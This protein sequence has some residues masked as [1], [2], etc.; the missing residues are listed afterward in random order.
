MT[1]ELGENE[2]HQ[3]GLKWRIGHKNFVKNFKLKQAVLLVENGLY[4][5]QI[6]RHIFELVTVKSKSGVSF[7]NFR[8]ENSGGRDFLPK[9]FEDLVNRN[10]M[11]VC[12]GDQDCL[13]PTDHSNSNLMKKYKKLK[14]KK[15]VGF[16]KFTP[17][18]SIENFFSLTIVELLATRINLSQVT[19]L[20]KLIANQKNCK[21]QDCMWLYFDIKKGMIR[22]DKLKKCGPC[23]L[24]WLAGKYNIETK[25]VQ[26]IKF[27]GFGDISKLLLNNFNNK[28]ENAV[29]E[30]FKKFIKTDYWNQHINPWLEPILWFFCGEDTNNFG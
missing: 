22:K 4:D 30:E 20:K 24:K 26:N 28:N 7:P 21:K 11:V 10:E 12:I 3:D 2:I 25:E 5:G 6:Y 23:Q 18:N 16:A 13:A 1:I 27:D 8:P 17:G 9:W 14:S 19:K 15:F 29:K